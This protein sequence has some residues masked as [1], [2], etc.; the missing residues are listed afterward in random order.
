MYNENAKGQDPDTS[1]QSVYESG[2]SMAFQ[3]DCNFREDFREDAPS[4]RGVVGGRKKSE[5]PE[6]ECTLRYLYSG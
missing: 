3:S 1:V 2:A 4:I 6:C 5:S